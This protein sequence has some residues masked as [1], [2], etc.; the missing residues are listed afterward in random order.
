MIKGAPSKGS[1]EYRC[2]IE[3]LISK[4]IK[5]QCASL[6]YSDKNVSW[7][8]NHCPSNATGY[9]GFTKCESNT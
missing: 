6:T 9:N 3:Y 4:S 5:T 8:T 1:L 7:N 2:Y